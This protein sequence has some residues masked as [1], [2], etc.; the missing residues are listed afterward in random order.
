M[1]FF[2]DI[3]DLD[4][5]DPSNKLPTNALELR[6]GIQNG[7][8]QPILK[9]YPRIKQSGRYHCFQSSWLK[10]YHWLEYSEVL[11]KYFCFLCRVFS[12]NQLNADQIDKTCSKTGFT[13][14]YKGIESFRKHH[15]SKFHV[16]S[17]KSMKN[18]HNEAVLPID[19]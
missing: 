15:L 16:N 6:K 9:L 7:P 12:G 2:N 18:Y 11:D 3:F 8:F 14:W 5:D 1:F 17:V 13:K 19:Q 10:N 4:P